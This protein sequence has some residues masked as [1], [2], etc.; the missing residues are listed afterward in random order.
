MRQRV[1]LLRDLPV[2]VTVLAS[3]AFFVALG[4]G[5]VIPSIPIFADSFGVSALA[6]SAVVSAFALMRFVSS[7]LAG[8]WTNRFGERGVLATGLA[9]VAVSSFFAGLSQS[10]AQLLILR[11]IG[12]IGSSMFTVSAMALLLRVVSADQRG[13]ASAAWQGGFLIGGVSGPAIGGLVLAISIRAPFFFY[14]G[15][16]AIATIVAIV[17]LSPR[18]IAQREKAVEAEGGQENERASGW[19]ELKQALRT[20]AYRAALAVSLASGLTTFGLRS[21]LIPLFVVEGLKQGPSL[22]GWAFLVAAVTQALLLLPAGRL[23]DMR[24][25]RPAMII[26]SVASV[27]GMGM[28]V[29]DD[30]ATG[31]PSLAL[32]VFFVSM[33]VMGVATA[34]IGS[35]PSAVVGDIM[36]G[37]QGGSVVAAYQMVSDLGAVVGPLVGGLLLDLYGFDYAFAFGAA[38]SAIA[39][40]F[41]LVM[42]ETLRKSAQA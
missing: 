15:T 18:R 19:T 35:A 17:F 31:S 26:G 10:Y 5:I 30:L 4:F 14:A 16:L 42:P 25:R 36:G 38:I 39:L 8:A 40:A 6:A 21:A 34:F 22:S 37:R 33:G 29:A 2:E 27:V 7:P 13:R 12:G 1:P 41:V 20:R 32:I 23:T 11:G 9:I 24:G 28:L 3:I